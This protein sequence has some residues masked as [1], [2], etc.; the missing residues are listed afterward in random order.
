MNSCMTIFINYTKYEELIYS[1]HPLRFRFEQNS[2]VCKQKGHS[3]FESERDSC[4]FK[5]T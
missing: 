2:Q 5:G 1:N 4:D 3:Y